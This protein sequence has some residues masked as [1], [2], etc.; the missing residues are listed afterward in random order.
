MTVD[1]FPLPDRLIDIHN[2][3]RRDDDGSGMIG[4]MDAW[5]IERTLIM[6]TEHLENETVL[7]LVRQ[8][9]DRFLGGAYLDP[10]RPDALEQMRRWHGEGFRIVKL[11]PN[12]GYYPDDPALTPFFEQVA[13]L[14]MAVLSHCGWLMPHK[15]MAFASYYAT[16]GRFEKLVR[17]FTDTIFIM[18]HMGGING[19][20]ETVM[21]TTRAPN[22]YVDCSPGQGLWALQHGGGIAASVPVHKLLWGADSWGLEK[23]VPAYHDALVALGHGEHLAAIF[24][25]NAQKLLETIGLLPKGEPA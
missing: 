23:M 17:I 8:F 15:G 14:K 20:L 9:P 3:P 11:F 6:G 7:R 24:H 13:E 4:L 12:Y 21:L 22:V 19:L 2:H 1:E 25:D 10:R 5:S 18:A 16:P